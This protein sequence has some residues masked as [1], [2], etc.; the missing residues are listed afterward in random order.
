M[1]SLLTSWV[2][3][4]MSLLISAVILPGI[5]I[6]STSTAVY[7]AVVLGMLNYTAKPCFKFFTFPCAMFTFGLFSYV[8]DGLIPYLISYFVSGFYVETLLDSI[9]CAVII[10]LCSKFLFA[11]VDYTNTKFPS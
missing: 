9:L 2:I 8:I 10:H 7:A 6:N 11:I 5:H 3:H 4:A 1:A